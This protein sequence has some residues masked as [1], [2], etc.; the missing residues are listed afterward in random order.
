[1]SNNDKPKIVNMFWKRTYL[2]I[3]YISFKKEA[4]CID[5]CKDFFVLDCK[6]IGLNKYRAKINI[7]TQNNRSMLT[8]GE[9]KILIGDK[10]QLYELADELLL[11]LETLSAVFRYDGNKAYIVT[12]HI[13]THDTNNARIKFRVDYMKK[14]L[15]HKIRINKYSLLKNAVNICYHLL[16]FLRIK[17][18]NK[19]LFLSETSDTMSGNLKAIYDRLIERGLTNNYKI[20]CIFDN[21]VVHGSSIKYWVKLFFKISESDYIFV[22]DYVP[23]F[24]FLNLDKKTCLVQTWHAGF[25]YKAVGYGRFGLKGSPNPHYSSHRAYTYALVGNEHLKEIYSEVFGIDSNSLLPTGMPRLDTFLK[26]S[27]INA[28]KSEF[29]EHHPELINKKI[30]LFAPTYRGSNQNKAYYD[31]NRIDQKRLYEYCKANNAIILFKFHHFIQDTIIINKEYKKYLYDFTNHE[32]HSLLYVSDV[33]ITD[34]SSCFYDYLLLEKPIIF[35]IYD[36]AIFT[37]TRG[38]HRPVGKTAP[39]TIC[40]SMDELINTLNTEDYKTNIKIPECMIDAAKA[41][42]GRSASD[43]V[44]DYILLGKRD[45]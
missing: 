24:L 38:V 33:L 22:D 8:D 11:N 42:Y 26:S 5:N 9:W 25:G 45:L 14:N 34:Y 29:Y 7:C 15:L 2:F 23:I 6:E 17:R 30:V 16:S 43:K 41:N 27:N 37:A 10:F 1:M 35:Y 13:S 19:I 31:Y 20:N 18:K 44:L 3:E 36:E 21:I 28:A 12:F 39:G 4:I 40:R 32:I